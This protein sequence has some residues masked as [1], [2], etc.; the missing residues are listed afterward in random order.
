MKK[1]KYAIIAIVVIMTIAAIFELREARQFVR[2]E[3]CMKENN[4][5][6]SDANCEHC[7]ELSK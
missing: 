1:A 7:W 3:Q 6:Y 4:F 2:F 5:E